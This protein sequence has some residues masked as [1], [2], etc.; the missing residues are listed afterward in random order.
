VAW[1]VEYTDEFEEWWY[2][3]DEPEQA[4]VGTA[5]EVLAVMGPALTFPR[6]SRITTSRHATMRELRIQHH[7]RPYRVLY[8]FDP[9]RAALLILGGDKTGNDRWYEQNVPL[10]DVIYDRYLQELEQEQDDAENT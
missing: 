8:A 3:L 6:S 4:S 5:V 9:H 7:G 2:S 10:A 1:E